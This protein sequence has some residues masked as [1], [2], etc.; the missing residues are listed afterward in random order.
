MYWKEAEIYKNRGAPTAPQLPSSAPTFLHSPGSTITH[1]LP[2]IYV[3][4]QRQNN[5]TSIPGGSSLQ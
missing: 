2:P 1:F 5:P 4:L 3:T